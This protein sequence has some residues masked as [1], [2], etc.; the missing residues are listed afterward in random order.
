MNYLEVQKYLFGING[1]MLGGTGTEYLNFLP[2]Q[3]HCK[4]NNN[5]FHFLSKYFGHIL[6]PSP[7]HTDSQ[8]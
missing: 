4:I 7:P 5:I 2:D 8:W 3:F 6:L 1:L